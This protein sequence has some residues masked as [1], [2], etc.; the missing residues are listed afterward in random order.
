M[1]NVYLEKAAASYAYHY[2]KAVN[3]TNSI[4]SRKGLSALDSDAPEVE[5]DYKSGLGLG[6][7]VTG[8]VLGTVAI[9]IPIAG[10]AAGYLLGRKY[11]RNKAHQAFVAKNSKE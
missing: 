3:Q 11:D 6:G 8:A 10:T 9:P 4:R 2:N 1:S 5:N 7:R